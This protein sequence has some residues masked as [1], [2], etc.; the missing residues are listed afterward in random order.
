[1]TQLLTEVT[2]LQRE[3]AVNFERALNH[4]EKLPGNSSVKASFITTAPATPLVMR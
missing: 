1:M 3:Q 4:G 2:V